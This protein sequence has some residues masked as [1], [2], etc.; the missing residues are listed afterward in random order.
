MN[1]FVSRSPWCLTTLDEM[2]FM[3]NLY[4][5]YNCSFWLKGGVHGL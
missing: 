1:S 3:S 4:L 2:S 5:E